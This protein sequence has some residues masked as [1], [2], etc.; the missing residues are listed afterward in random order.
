MVAVPGLPEIGE[1]ADFVTILRDALGDVEWPDGS[2]GVLDGDILVISS[3]V[4]SKAEGQWAADRD[5]AVEADT[6]RTVATRGDLRIVEN[7]LGVVM[8]SAGVDR[9]NTARVLRLPRD[10]D[11][12][13]RRIS[14]VL[15][16]AVVITDSAGRPWR[17]GITD[18]AIGSHGI[19]PLIDLRGLPDDNG[20]TLEMTQVGVADEIAAAAD[21]V[22]GKTGRTPVAVVR[23]LRVEGSGTAADLVR[24]S[25]EDLFSLGTREAKQAAVTG[26]RTVRAFTD[27]PVPLEFIQDAVA[28]ACTAPSPHHTRPWR[29]VLLRDARAQVL[30]AMRE[31]WI[32]DLRADG[33]SQESIDKRVRR[34][35]VL[36]N[37]PEVVLAFSELAGAAHDY[38]DERRRGFE[39]DLFLVAGGAAVEN[40]LVALS[41]AGLGSAW[42]SSTVFCPPVVA[43][44]LDVPAT[45]QPLGAIA[46]GWPEAPAA[47]RAAADL[48]A[49]FLLR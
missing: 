2:R 4:V 44:A 36:W 5:E 3:K 35:D 47:E 42:I 1:D 48:T 49:H 15:G 32:A 28:A 10:P 18:F 8:A 37:A 34:G 43:A 25:E 12:S 29:F 16:L 23:G 39:R 22:K 6:V 24:T 26:R 41:A 33:F 21:L 45:W 13:A 7:H 11:V 17:V 46:I 20:Q 40:L 9:S 31:Q 38:P 14:E 27:E 30:G 19:S